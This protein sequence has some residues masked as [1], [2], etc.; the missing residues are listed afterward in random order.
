MESQSFKLYRV[1]HHLTGEEQTIGAE[2]AQ[3]ACERLGWLI[4][5][6][7]VRILL[8]P[9]DY[10]NRTRPPWPLTPSDRP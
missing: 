7:Y 3:E 2:S 8:D 4:G 6:C 9:N 1:R 10:A 5:N